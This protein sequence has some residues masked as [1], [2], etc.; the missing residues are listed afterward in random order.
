[1]NVLPT[2]NRRQG[3]LWFK[4]MEVS[5]K[6]KKIGK[7][8]PHMTCTEAHMAPRPRSKIS[9]I[10]QCF[11]RPFKAV[12]NFHVI[13]AQHSGNMSPGGLWLLVATVNGGGFEEWT[14]VG[15]NDHRR[16]DVSP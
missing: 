9:S 3:L 1:M 13:E 4:V 8:K 15:V 16:H 12:D 10:V 2:L 7:K 14:G 6:S 5:R 11:R